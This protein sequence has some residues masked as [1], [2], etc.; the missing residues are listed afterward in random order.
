MISQ[1]VFARR[2]ASNGDSL[3]EGGAN[4]NLQLAGIIVNTGAA[5]AVVTVFASNPS[6]AA[7]KIAVIDAS[8]AA[9]TNPRNWEAY[10]AQCKNGLSV[11][12]TGGN[13]DVTVLF[14]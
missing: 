2:L 8:T 7:S 1:P 3:S 10:G 12:L 4:S 6:L 11:Y 13:A 14:S 5:S 9:G